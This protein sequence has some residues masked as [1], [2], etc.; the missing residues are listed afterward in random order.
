ML[1]EQLGLNKVSPTCISINSRECERLEEKRK[2]VRKARLKYNWMRIEEQSWHKPGRHILRWTPELASCSPSLHAGSGNT[3]FK[4]LTPC[5]S[6]YATSNRWRCSNHVSA[7]LLFL[8]P[9]L[10]HSLN[11][12]ETNR[13]EHLHFW[14]GPVNCFVRTL[15]MFKCTAILKGSS[16]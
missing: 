1:D 12:R 10:T 14:P 6:R 2:K 15:T 11:K 8:S 7:G 5:L 4:Q 9:R 16:V 3:L 13:C